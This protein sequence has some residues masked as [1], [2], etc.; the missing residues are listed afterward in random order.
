MKKVILI[1]IFLFIRAES[2]FLSHAGYQV[3]RPN[4][5]V[6]NNS[7]FAKTFESRQIQPT[8]PQPSQNSAN[9]QQRSAFQTSDNQNT[10]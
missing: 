3:Q 6:Q 7:E 9:L 8:S 5:L 1:V 4:P 2:Q 10:N